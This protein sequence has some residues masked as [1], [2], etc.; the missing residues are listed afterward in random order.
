M[1]KIFIGEKEKKWTN[2]GTDT[3]EEVDSILHITTSHTQFSWVY[4]VYR[5]YINTVFVLSVTMFE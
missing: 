1:T 5:R 3:Y 2:R 4:E